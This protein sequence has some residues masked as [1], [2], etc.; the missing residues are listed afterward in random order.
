MP[1]W[2]G[3]VVEAPR[4]LDP[5]TRAAAAQLTAGPRAVAV[6]RHGRPS[7]TDATAIAVTPT[8]TSSCRTAAARAAGPG[9]LSHH[10]CFYLRGGRR[11]RRVARAR[12]RL[13]VIADLLCLC[14]GEAARDALAVPDEALRL[15]EPRSDEFRAA[16]AR[17][18]ASSGRTTAARC[19][20]RGLLDL[21]SQ[22]AESP[23]ESWLR[24]HPHRARLPAAR[25]QL[26]AIT[27]PDGRELSRLDLAWP[28]VAHLR[29][30][31][32]LDTHAG[33]EDADAAREAELRRRGWIVDPRGRR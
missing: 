18:A 7:C 31:R 24:L 20:A 5:L 22:R 30:V 19:A 2:T 11:D 1:L 8:S 17:P 32:R 25:G 4:L 28:R 3:V 16:V 14:R 13:S 26:G 9:S 27:T 21:A 23:P 29:R 6:R 15:A 10:S 12:A 33:R